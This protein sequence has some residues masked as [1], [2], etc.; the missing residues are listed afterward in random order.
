[1]A[2]NFMFQYTQAGRISFDYSF[3][4]KTYQFEESILG[5]A[6]VALLLLLLILQMI[7]MLMHRM[8]TLQ[9]LLA[10]TE[11]RIRK[12]KRKDASVARN[13]EDAIRQIKAVLQI[14]S[15]IDNGA[16]TT[17]PAIAEKNNKL[18]VT[19]IGASN[20]GS[21]GLGK[22]TN[23]ERFTNELGKSLKHFG[24]IRNS[25]KEVVLDRR[26]KEILSSARQ[27]MMGGT[28]KQKIDEIDPDLAKSFRPLL[29]P[30]GSK[31]NPPCFMQANNFGFTTKELH[32]ANLSTLNLIDSSERARDFE[33]VG[34][35]GRTLLQKTKI[36]NEV[37]DSFSTGSSSLHWTHS[38][39]GGRKR[40]SYT[41]NNNFHSRS[42]RL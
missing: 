27:R 13:R 22:V 4:G 15:M 38:D 42:V 5:F 17:P 7:G 14:P 23:D 39:V 32:D 34:A 3:G 29:P 6:F 9:H 1:M 24:N 36:I 33:G 11:I 28:V 26:N 2:L 18:G 41:R 25:S 19:F 40:P 10:I 35:M 20:K 12:G 37:A 8:S 30:R 31:N 16:F 21:V